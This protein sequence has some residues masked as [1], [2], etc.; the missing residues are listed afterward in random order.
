MVQS[1]SKV[2]QNGRSD[3]SRESPQGRR[4]VEG[5]STQMNTELQRQTCPVEERLIDY[6]VVPQSQQMALN[7]MFSVNGQKKRK[8]RVI[9]RIN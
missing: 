3:Y 2:V 4:Q 9:H 7:G 1:N 8:N 6:P 5:S